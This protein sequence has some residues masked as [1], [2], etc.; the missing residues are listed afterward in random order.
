MWRLGGSRASLYGACSVEYADH[1]GRALWEPFV[2]KDSLKT[3]L[4]RALKVSGNRRKQLSKELLGAVPG[5]KGEANSEHEAGL[6]SVPRNHRECPKTMGEEW[7]R[8]EVA[9]HLPAS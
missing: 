8:R 2:R 9:S 1:I 5:Q 3:D 4:P 7:R 6:G